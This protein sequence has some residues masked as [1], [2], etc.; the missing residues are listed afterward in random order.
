[1]FAPKVDYS[2][3]SRG[4]R[5]I[6]IELEDID[7]NGLLDIIT[8][9][10][11]GNSVSVL[12]GNED[13]TFEDRID[14][15]TVNK[16][17]STLL[18]DLDSDGDL[19][20]IV[21]GDTLG[22]HFNN[23]NGAV[24]V[25]SGE[26]T[27]TYES[28][29]NQLSSAT[30]ELGRITLYDIDPDNGNNLS[31][32]K[33]VGAV[34]GADD[35]ITSYT[36][37]AAGLMDTMTDPEGRV[38]DYEYDLFGRLI[39]TTYALGTADEATVTYEYDA[40]GNQT[41]ITDE[42]GNRTEFEYDALNRIIKITEADPDGAGALESPITTFDYDAAGNL[43]S[44]TDS[45]NKTTEYTYDEKNRQISI[46][47]AND[48]ITEFDYDANDNLIEITD[49]E[50]RVTK[51]IYDSRDRLIGF[52]DG[53]GKITQFKYDADN[54]LT[55]II[56]PNG[57]E[58]KYI[59]DVRNRLIREIDAED[60]TTVYSYDST[61][62]LIAV[63]DA[64]G[65]KTR[66]RYDEL[67]RQTKVINPL[68]DSFTNQYDE[69][70][71]LLST[72]DELGRVYSYGYDSRNRLK[73]IIDPNLEEIE[74]FYD[75]VGNLVALED[76]LDRFTTFAYDGLNRNTQIL[77]PLFN[78]A[79]YTYDP[80][81]NLTSVT[82]K[83]NNTTKYT[84]DALNRLS[85]VENALGDTVTTDYD[86]VG[87]VVEVTDELNR[88]TT[89][90]YDNRN[91]LTSV[92]DALGNIT[93]TEFNEVGKISSV[94]DARNNTTTYEYDKLHRLIKEIDANNES[95]TYGYDP[96]GNLE[97]FTD[98]LDRTTRWA[99][100]SLN[101]QTSVTTPLEHTT[102]WAYDKVGNLTSLTDANNHTTSWTYDKLNR[103]TVLTNHLLDTVTT[104]YDAVGNVIA[105]TDEL[106]RTTTFTYDK[107][108]RQKTV[109]NPLIHTDTTEYDAVGNV[110]SFT[111]D[112]GHQ[113]TYNYDQ[114]NRL[115][116]QTDAENR[117]TTYGYDPV[118]NLL[119]L[120]DPENNTTSYTYD[121]LNRLATDTNQLG[122]TRTY[123]YDE[124][125]NQVSY[126]D[127]NGR[128]INYTYD[129]LNRQENEV[130]L[131]ELGNP[132]RNINFQYDAAS[133]L[134]TA[135]DPD[136]AYSYDYDLDGRL[137]SVDNAGTPDVPNVVFNYTYDPVDNLTQVTDRIDG[138]DK[139]IETFTYDELDRV[140][141][142]TQ[143]GGDG[144]SEKRVDMSYDK[145]SQMKEI[146]RY[147]DLAGTQLVAESNYT[148]DD[149]GRLTDLVHD[150]NGT[151]F[152]D[153]QWAY[154][155]ANRV[156]S[157]TSFDG[158]SNYDYDK[159][160]QLV[161]AEHSYQ[162]DEDYSY[163]NNGNR[164][165][166]GYVT[167]DNNQLISDGTYNYEYDNEGNRVKRT[168]IATG[169]VTEYEWDYR[170]R[171]VAVVTKDAGG[172]VIANSEYTY[173]V[174]NRRIAKSVD[175][176]GDGAG[177][178]EVERFVYDGDHIA[179]TFDGEG[180]QTE[181]FLHG[182]GIDQ[183]LAQE[184]ASGDE[185][186]WAL[187]DNQGSVKL[188]TDNDGNIV[189]QI[190]YDAFGNITLE[191]DS[192]VSFR[193]SYTG[194]ELDEE[195]GLY[196]Y[197]SRPYDPVNGVF[198]QEDT[199]GFAG[200]DTNLSRYV[201]NSP[202]NYTDPFGL[203]PVMARPVN[204]PAQKNFRGNIRTAPRPTNRNAPRYPGA[205]SQPFN[206]INPSQ[207][208]IRFRAPVNGQIPGLFE[209]QLEELNRPN[210]PRPFVNPTCI[211]APGVSC[212]PQD[213]FNPDNQEDWSEW[214]ERMEELIEEIRENRENDDNQQDSEIQACSAP[215]SEPPNS[216]DNEEENNDNEYVYRGDTRPPSEI[217]AD[218]GFQPRNPDGNIS[219]REHVTQ[220]RDN[221][222]E[223]LSDIFVD[224]DTES[225]WVST[226]NNEQ[227]A[228]TYSEIVNRE[229]AQTEG[230]GYVYRI[231]R[232][233]GGRNVF[234]EVGDGSPNRTEISFEG[235]FSRQYIESY[236]RVLGRDRGRYNL[237][238]SIPFPR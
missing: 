215:I 160:D 218:G 9:N 148:F 109:T 213:P 7:N 229:T 23:F 1:S 126:I 8:S 223:D 217:F 131:D 208:P 68:G 169:E 196:Y 89:F 128:E 71:N 90:A 52:V 118:S 159:T 135:D 200:G 79:S 111:N 21:Q 19:D 72:T 63:E 173:D 130:W 67:N 207:N 231:R 80:L 2:T 27:F 56:D 203:R 195:T 227:H 15:P 174:Y 170:N 58:A 212:Q 206:Q 108:N 164:T 4:S 186:L 197:R 143:S 37:T 87:N 224:I 166:T 150:Q 34:G 29:F 104:D 69:V 96:V 147:S 17:S 134:L 78:T 204:R 176:D 122:N 178:A 145:A 32:T 12:L 222:R 51:N 86:A 149:A 199:I 46:T 115:E 74:Y 182:A 133:Q 142:I 129:N 18:R 211:S 85:V 190:T 57:N 127:R 198:I 41:A 5:S 234:L 40:A 54:N 119:S 136:S 216:N 117:T 189:N 3:A 156:T 141:S 38:T 103:P 209:E 92:K 184:N 75:P 110:I 235:G 44:T 48:E 36:Y 88:T 155:S 201:G 161:D 140:K 61:D 105:V 179:L 120:T 82:D 132:V 194:R 33:V 220:I 232:P 11:L 124:V 181:R 98:E 99:Y 152:A 107:L 151:I 83:R 94:T 137:T 180:N 226:T 14:I 20:L 60:N 84:Y 47:D 43:I 163:D 214:V 22:V 193:F 24:K 16:P 236:R 221:P 146:T 138:V 168:E 171:L 210:L 77:D 55:Q 144:V 26:R 187:T 175:A 62:N 172:N 191:T 102:R 13:G 93:T 25:K 123:D 35:L 158:V 73:S 113:T 238:P 45:R 10:P 30:D 167:G 65:H 91:L 53:E 205:S 219:L 230:Y 157:Y 6:A 50:G 165:N 116:S 139:G 106:D 162:A 49:A 225:Q 42:N 81:G 153:Y 228:A 202:T 100:D 39:S 66:F 76:E 121:N 31:T 59:Y 185:V 192:S 114:L 125:G 183:V 188:V 177:V 101:R 112:L 233:P 28:T 95:V 237:G 64:R 154:D 70:G 97:S